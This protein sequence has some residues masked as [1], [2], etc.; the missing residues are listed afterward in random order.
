MKC[1]C[2]QEEEEEEEEDRVSRTF[3]INSEGGGRWG[4]R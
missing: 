2:E 3:K 4:K 1:E